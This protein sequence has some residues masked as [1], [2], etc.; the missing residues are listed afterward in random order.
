MNAFKYGVLKMSL[1]WEVRKHTPPVLLANKA[2]AT[3]IRLGDAD[4]AAVQQA[5][6][7]SSRGGVK[8]AS[9]AGTLFNHS[10]DKRGYQDIH[11]L[12][13]TVQKKEL[14]GLIDD[15]RFP[16]T[17]N[18]RYQSH[19][20]AAAELV[21]FL[22]L[23]VELL[24]QVRDSKVK[25]GF[26]HVEANL[27]RALQDVPTI[28]ELS[29]MTLYGISLS[30]PYLRIVRGNGNNIQNLLSSELID[31]HRRLPSFC[32][33]VAANPSLLLSREE[34]VDFSKVT[35][36]SK[37]WSHPM[38]VMAIQVMAPDLPDLE[39]AISDIFSG[40]ADGWRQF[41]QE[42]IPGGPFDSL[43]TEQRSRLFIPATNDANEGAL[44][45]WRV[46][47][48]Y[49]PSS[50]AAGFS[51][52]TRL[53]RNNTEHFIEKHCNEEDQKYVMRAVRVQSA[54]GENARFR[55]HLIEAQRK[56]MLATRQKQETVER[57]RREEIERLTKVGLVVDRNVIEKMTVKQL[58]DQLNIYTKILDDDVLRKVLKKDLK[59]KAIKCSAVL[60]ALARNDE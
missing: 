46:W 7:S 52:K 50:T 1:G 18:T 47:R 41:T 42:F 40:G 49:H 5:V 53:E 14:H 10:D 30:W 29:A 19:T 44:G 13:M 4:S 58:D 33:Y 20:Y 56:R 22:D 28:T 15:T 48:R 37:P 60:A 36:D 34:T 3:T 12:F 39:A 35:L 38:A 25:S 43:T 16:D 59:L 8:A 45:S 21:T 32:E 2:N 9:L 6:D 11:C 31:L 51:N 27:Y 54:S 24:E 26:N 55:Q 17:S 23:Y 57:K